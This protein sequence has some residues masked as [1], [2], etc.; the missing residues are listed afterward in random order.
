MENGDFLTFVLRITDRDKAAAVINPLMDAFAGRVM[1]PGV[2]ITAVSMED[3]MTARDKEQ[4][5]A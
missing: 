1:L 4:E 5:G 3:E 2:E